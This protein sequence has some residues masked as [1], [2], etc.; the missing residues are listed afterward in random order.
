MAGVCCVCY[1]SGGRGTWGGKVHSEFA[2]LGEFVSTNRDNDDDD[3]DDND[4]DDWP[5][6]LPDDHL[7]RTWIHA[8]TLNFAPSSFTL[9]A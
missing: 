3:N 5:G 8:T 1:V 2:S 7:I 6:P 9:S 4:D